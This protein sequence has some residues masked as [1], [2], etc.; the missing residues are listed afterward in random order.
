MNE[1]TNERIYV[2]ARSYA[3]ADA[4]ARTPPSPP[5]YTHMFTFP[6]L[7]MARVVVRQ[8]VRKERLRVEGVH[9]SPL[10]FS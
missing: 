10:P 8:A 9:L 5:R 7:G 6:L 4:Q 2:Q 3:D 1:R